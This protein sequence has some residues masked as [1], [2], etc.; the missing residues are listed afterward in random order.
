M[1]PMLDKIMYLLY[2]S[3]MYCVSGI[4]VIDEGESK[5]YSIAEETGMWVGV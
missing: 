2:L 4:W 5:S 1:I 3:H